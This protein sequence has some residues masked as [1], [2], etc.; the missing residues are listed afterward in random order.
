[1]GAAFRSAVLLLESRGSDKEFIQATTHA[2]VFL[3]ERRCF[4]FG[5]LISGHFHSRGVAG[6]QWERCRAYVRAPARERVA[7]APP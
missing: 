7:T 3:C 6:R 4:L 5:N 2:A 1:M